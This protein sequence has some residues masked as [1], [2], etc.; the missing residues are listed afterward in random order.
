MF[1]IIAFG[2]KQY[3]VAPKDKIIVDKV[4]LHEGEECSFERVLL[5]VKN[6]KI[7][8]GTP[9]LDGATV[10]GRVLKHQKGEKITILKYK[11]KKR[12][13]KKKGARASFSEI[14][15]LGI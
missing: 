9:C 3:I 10:R 13:K 11:A 14:E 5:R 6:K 4:S 15:I 1:A 12:Y 2:G 7:E 8:I